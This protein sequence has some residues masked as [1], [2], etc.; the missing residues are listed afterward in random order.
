MNEFRAFEHLVGHYFK[1]HGLLDWSFKWD[2]GKRRMGYCSATKNVVSMSIIG[3]TL[4]PIEDSINTL[5][6]EI[7]HALVGCSNGHNRIW[8]NKCIEIGCS[9]TRTFNIPAEQMA[10]PAYGA[11]CGCCGKI[12]TKYRK[13]KGKASCGACQNVYNDKYRLI[14]R[15]CKK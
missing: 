7:A 14:F 12:H 5:L 3:Y 2:K 9:P 10:K 15:R 13:T 6:H 8:K 11:T 4:R 1:R